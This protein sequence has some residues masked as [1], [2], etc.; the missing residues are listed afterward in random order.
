VATQSPLAMRYND[1][2]PLGQGSSWK[3]AIICLIPIHQPGIDERQQGRCIFVLV[4]VSG[5]LVDCLRS[6]KRTRHPCAQSSRHQQ[7]P[8]C[9]ATS[10]LWRLPC[11]SWSQLH[12]RNSQARLPSAAEGAEFSMLQIRQLCSAW[13]CWLAALTAL[14]ARKVGHA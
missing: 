5:C 10:S 7:F 2:S 9:R 8:L 11:A 12:A 1:T 14:V 13:M 3:T 6:F 4:H